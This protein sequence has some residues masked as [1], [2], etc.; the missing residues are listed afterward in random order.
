MIQRGNASL[1]FDTG[2]ELVSELAV[3]SLEIEEV[4]E[5]IDCCL[6]EGNRKKF[7]ELCVEREKLIGR[8]NYL[9]KFLGY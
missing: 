2:L 5:L 9:H 6:M 4:D 3:L 8:I 1:S 7:G